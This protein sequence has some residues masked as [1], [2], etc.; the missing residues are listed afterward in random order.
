MQ[1]SFTIIMSSSDSVYI[2]PTVPTIVTSFFLSCP[3]YNSGSYV[4]VSGQVSPVS[5]DLECFFGLSLSFSISS[6]KSTRFSF[7]KMAHPGLSN[8]S[9]CPDSGHAFLAGI[10]Q[11][12]CCALTSCQW[13]N[14]WRCYSP[15]LRFS[16]INSHFP[17]ITG[18]DLGRRPQ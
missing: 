1:V 6:R 3:G 12:W 16:T 13:C 11:E 8:L 15:S 14:H 9:S 7:C 10:L 2:L 5:L 17:F 4:A 18:K